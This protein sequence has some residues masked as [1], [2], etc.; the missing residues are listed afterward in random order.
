MD[1]TCKLCAKCLKADESLEKCGDPKCDNMIHPSCGRKIAAMFKEGEW[2]GSLFCSK[3]CFKQHKKS[4]ASAAMRA[5][6]RVRWSTDGLVPEIS[7]MSIMV[8]WLTMD[9]NY[10]CWRGGVKQNG[11]TKSVIANQ[12]VQLMQEKGII[13][14]RTGKIV[15]NRINCLE[16]Q[17]RGAQ[18]GWIKLGLAWLMRKVLGQV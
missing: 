16:Q 7:S 1:S 8:D 17:F 14:P 18:I 9:D 2:E 12:L 13:I 6:G 10:N 5:K 3:H 4:P 11:S 15:H